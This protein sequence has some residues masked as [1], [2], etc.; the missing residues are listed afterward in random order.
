M[1]YRKKYIEEF[2]WWASLFWLYALLSMSIFVAFLMYSF[3]LPKLRTCL[4]APIKIHN[5]AMGV[6]CVMAWVNGEKYEN[7]LPFNTSWLASLRTCYILDFVPASVVLAMTL[8]NEK[9]PHVKF[10]FV[11]TTVLIKN[12]T[13]QTCCW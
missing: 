7:L 8:H 12:K 11:F 9:E 1:S 10:L 6:F 13:L 3:P 5:I 2:V 4:M